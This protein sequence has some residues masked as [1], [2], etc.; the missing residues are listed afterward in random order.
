MDMRR[1]PRLLTL[2]T[3][4]IHFDAAESV[5]CA[6]FDINDTGACIVVPD[7]AKIPETFDLAIDPTGTNYT[8]RVAWRS[9]YKIGVSFQLCQAIE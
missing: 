1:H 5:L 4:K 6:I 7:A 8:C 3:G 9:R 2:K